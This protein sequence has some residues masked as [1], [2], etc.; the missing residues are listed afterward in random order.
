LPVSRSIRVKKPP[1]KKPVNID[2][3]NRYRNQL[4]ALKTV[5]TSLKSIVVDESVISSI[6]NVVLDMNNI[7]THTYYFLKLFCLTMFN[8]LDALPRIDKHLIVLIMKTISKADDARGREF[9]NKTK[10]IQSELDKFFI[11]HYKPLM[12][13]NAPSY[14]GFGNMLEYEAESILTGLSNH[15]QEN[16]DQMVNRYINIMLN[17]IELESKCLN[18]QEKKIVRAELRKVKKDILIGRDRESDHRDFIDDFRTTILKD[19]IVN[20]SLTYTT[21][22]N[23]LSL[24]IVAIRMS[25]KSENEL[26][27]RQTPEKLGQQVKVINCFPLRKSIIPKYVDFDTS[28]LISK[29][30]DENIGYYN[31]DK[32]KLADEIWRKFF[33]LDNKVFKKKGYMFNRRISTDGIGCSIFFIRNDLYKSDARSYV[34]HIKKPKNY[35]DDIYVNELS[36]EEKLI[37]KNKRIIGVDPGMNDLIVCTNGDVAL[38]EKSNGKVFRHAT[39][40][41]FS[42]KLRVTLTKSKIY[43]KHMEYLKNDK[44]GIWHVN[45]AGDLKIRSPT[46]LETELSN[47]NSGSCIL[48][49]AKSYIKKK[50]EINHILSTLYKL[51]EF[52]RWKWYGYINRQRADR[53][54]VKR[55]KEKFGSGEESVILIGDF[56]QRKQMKYKEPTKGKS[57]RTLFKKNGYK[58][59]LVDEYRT[60]CRL[61]ETGEELINVRGCHSLLGSK[62]LKSR[63]TEN[64][65]DVFIKDMIKCGYRPTIINRDL[66][67]SLNI[68]IKG[69][70]ILHNVREP[71]YTAR[72]IHVD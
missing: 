53:E 1:D 9:S 52:R 15:L 38:K 60:S 21:S 58:V 48:E 27:K 46:E 11:D 44:Y 65:P 40:Y 6:S 62:I 64:K 35:S 47:Y 17:K 34:K 45:R 67:G 59:Y 55:F 66:N 2:A 57:I 20:K 39:C 56:E 5:K 61:Y 4:T 14:T 54:M 3:Y 51:P 71:E 24:L 10:Q 29:L 43:A 70:C 37:A 30:I 25:I 32:L 8:D 7:V 49:N 36:D 12:I 18:K 28:I 26:L 22:S 42:Q 33:N 63:M 69:W 72:K 13:K 68:R 50:N 41:R 23:P 19:V 16:F 31:K